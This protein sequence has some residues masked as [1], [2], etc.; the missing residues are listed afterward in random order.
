MI[1]KWIEQKFPR[2]FVFGEFPNEDRV[3]VA[4]CQRDPIA[5]VT[6]EQAEALIKEHN[7]LL[8]LTIEIARALETVDKEALDKILL[9][10]R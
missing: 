1:D 2:F 7:G 10:S 3:D 4:S 8:D 5:T 6:R 9:G